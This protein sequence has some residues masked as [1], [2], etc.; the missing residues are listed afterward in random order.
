MDDVEEN[1]VEIPDSDVSNTSGGKEQ[2]E[3]EQ[4]GLDA[5][6][7]DIPLDNDIP[8]QIETIPTDVSSEG[9]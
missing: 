6:Q 5:S 1:I 3:E 8:V 9:F 4:T 2:R 7:N